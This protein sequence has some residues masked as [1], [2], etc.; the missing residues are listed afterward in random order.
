MATLNT[1]FSIATGAL[2]AEQAAVNV[3]ANNTA[4]ANTPGYTNQLPEW[5]ANDP[6]T[7]GEV[8]YGQGVTMTG[9]SSQRDL[10]LEQ[11]IQQ[12]MQLQQGTDAR[13][14]ALEQVQNIF[15]SAAAASSSHAS[16][17][18][19]A[20]ISGFFSALSQLQSNPA[21]NSLRQS[22]LS[23]ASTLAN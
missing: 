16:L 20:G 9:P 21:D 23:A 4:N 2:E 17:D 19:G 11:R 18:I 12:Q 13:Q 8:A 14:G 6:V 10:V 15:S 7:I 5:Q 3:I 22:V 1:A